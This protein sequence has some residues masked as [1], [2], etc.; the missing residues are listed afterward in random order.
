MNPDYRLDTPPPSSR[1]RRPWSPDPQD[2]LPPMP[3]AF[4]D[5]HFDAYNPGRHLSRQREP[6]D[7]SV[8][9]LDLADYAAHLRRDNN[10][11]PP[12]EFHAYDSYPPS[13]RAARPLA[14]SPD[15]LQ[16]PSLAS[17]SASSA[18]SISEVGHRVPNRRPFSLPPPSFP[19]RSPQS[20][21]SLSTSGRGPYDPYV[22]VAGTGTDSEIDIAAFPSFSRTWYGANKA[23]SPLPPPSSAP[24]HGPGATKLSPF[25]PAYPTPD[26][27][28]DPYN[29][30][31]FSPP[32]SYNP[33]SSRD[34]V[35]WGSDPTEA[36]APVDP[37]TK[38]ER[39]RM[40]QAE[41]GG[42]QVGTPGEDEE[43]VG[44]V[45]Q[46]GKL[47]TEGPTKRLAARCVQVLLV[48]A[49]CISSVYTGLVIKTT[50]TPPPKGKMAAYVLYVFSFVTLLA[51]IYMYMIRPCCCGAR[52]RKLDTPFGAE[53]PGGMMVLP[54]QGLPGGGKKKGKKK[55]GRGGGQG[56]GVQ[57]NLIVDPTMF[58]GGPGGR[59]RD[60]DEWEVEE[61]GEEG[62]APGSFEGN[63][64]K[65][66]GGPRRRGIFAGLA[67]EAQWKRARKQ[68]KVLMAFD[69]V[70]ALAWGVVFVVILM[71]KKCPVGGYLGWCDGYNVGTASAC[72][73]FLA[74]CFSIFFDI[75]DLHASKASPRTRP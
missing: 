43:K 16:P 46:K 44:S 73:L 57:V 20:H 23:H 21:P 15:S 34:L 7:V 69:C 64:G 2:L 62:S 32:P 31:T 33:R 35:P 74:F 42:K 26:Y 19:H 6:S 54:V 68:L 58:G 61:E 18:P 41:F 71:G 48:I 17:P 14:S 39:M 65:R 30:Y 63:G 13:P 12:P 38:E 51:C 29:P 11:Y 25:D 49:A 45:D 52:D 47:I 3:R 27:D 50:S 8:E 36:D 37:G 22:R 24:G 66:K 67:M 59:D 4:D 10:P 55:K 53:G 5:D 56:E 9:A 60:R 72:L 28:P 70:M 75:K 40:L 1:F